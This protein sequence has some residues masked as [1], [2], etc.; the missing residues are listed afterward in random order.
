MVSVEGYLADVADLLA[1]LIARVRAADPELVAI[2]DPALCGRVVAE[3]V[4]TR[5]PLPPF[6]NSQMDG[7]AVRAR[8]LAGASADHHVALPI[9]VTIAA[10]DPPVRHVPGTASP[11]MTGAAIP[12][13]ADAVVPVERTLPPAFPAL[14]RAGDRLVSSDIT[15]AAPIDL[16]TFVRRAAEDLPEG[17]AIVDAGAVLTPT[18]IGALASAGVA[19][20][21]VRRRVRVLICTTGDELVESGALPP[22]RIHDANGP[23]LAAMLRAAGADV[24]LLHSADRADALRDLIA[25][26]APRTDLLVTSGGISAGAYE[27]V[28]DALAP[29]GARFV[30]VAMQPGGP[31]GLGS[32]QLP[33]ADRP[34][35][36]LCFPGNP[37]STV[38]S[39][40]LFLLPALRELAGMP[41]EASTRVRPL[42]TD[43]HSPEHKLQ[44]RRGRIEADGSVT[45]LPPGSHLLHDLAE[46]DVIAQIPAGVAFAPAGTPVTTWRLHA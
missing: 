6:D 17:A 42:A 12:L 23:I 31:Q 2:G 41:R 35:P 16:G 18:R 10:G 4:R 27:V 32:L 44:L 28:R 46:A 20:A 14:S 33:R 30:G 25:V 29:L 8:D 40:S 19:T 45:P 1:P 39:A 7:Y 3:P 22:G 36:A 24:R 37:V 34:L 15:F 13:G 9:G 21:P 5:I 26:E 38:L 43:T 11:V